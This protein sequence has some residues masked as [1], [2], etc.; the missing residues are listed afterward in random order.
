[1]KKLKAKNVVDEVSLTLPKVFRI[2]EYS[3]KINNLRCYSGRCI[4]CIV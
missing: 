3:N 2:F 1:M 4:L